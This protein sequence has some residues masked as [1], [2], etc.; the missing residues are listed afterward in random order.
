MWNKICRI[1]LYGIDSFWTFFLVVKKYQKLGDEVA[2]KKKKKGQKY[3]AIIKEI[4]W[5]TLLFDKK[6]KKKKAHNSSIFCFCFY[7][8]LSQLL[9]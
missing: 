5:S 1:A 8:R 9:K 3:N 7:L 2:K 4:L 6:K